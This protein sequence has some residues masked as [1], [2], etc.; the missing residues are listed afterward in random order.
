MYSVYQLLI[1]S[2]VICNL[3]GNFCKTEVSCINF[4]RHLILLQLFYLTFACQILNQQVFNFFPTYK[5]FRLNLKLF[6]KVTFNLTFLKNDWE[7]G[8]ME[9]KL[10]RKLIFGNFEIDF[11]SFLK[12]YL[13][14]NFNSCRERFHKKYERFWLD[15]VWVHENYLRQNVTPSVCWKANVSFNIC[16][17]YLAWNFLMV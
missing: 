11:E 17:T 9:E 1:I 14:S 12:S 13:F 4:S 5:N 10:H 6:F 7:R 8:S 2:C 15:R 16:T 3:T